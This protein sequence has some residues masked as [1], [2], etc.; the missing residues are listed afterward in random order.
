M[1][2]WMNSSQVCGLVSEHFNEK[3][4]QFCVNWDKNIK[5][6]CLKK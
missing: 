6:I 1:K 5:E 2:E 4:V 3:A